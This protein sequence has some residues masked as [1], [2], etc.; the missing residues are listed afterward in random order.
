MIL[1]CNLVSN[2]KKVF[3]INTTND[4]SSFLLNVKNVRKSLAWSIYTFK[5][6]SAGDWEDAI[7]EDKSMFRFGYFIY[8]Y[9]TISQSEIGVVFSQKSSVLYEKIT[10]QFLTFV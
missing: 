5:N 7:W 9:T 2:I 4:T 3:M 8:T 1:N 6:I 10:P